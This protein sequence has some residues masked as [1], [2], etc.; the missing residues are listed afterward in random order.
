MIASERKTGEH[1][2][3]VYVSE[4]T[5]SA[6]LFDGRTITVPLSWHPRLL[7]ASAEQRPNWRIAGAGYGI[8]WPDPDEDLAARGLLQDARAPREKEEAA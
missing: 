5:L 4:D 1:V 3:N 7:H 6:D 2:K 8:H